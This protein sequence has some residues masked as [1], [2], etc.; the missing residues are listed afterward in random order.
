MTIRVPPGRAGRLWLQRRLAT[1]T[2]ATTLLE[3]KLRTLQKEERRLRLR[4]QRTAEWWS[5]SASEADCWLVR[6]RLACGDRAIRLATTAEPADVTIRWTT[7]M[8]A[9]YPVE[10]AVTPPRDPAGVVVVAGGAV[11]RA[12]AALREALLAGVSHAI[13]T[14]ALRVVQREIATTRQCVR[15][16]DR[17]WIPELSRALATLDLALEEQDRAEGLACRRAVHN[18]EEAR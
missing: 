16:L 9:S 10:G 3:Q 2:G 12:E 8:G 15:S 1:A 6:A 13:A 7:S 18:T 5:T 4:A 11:V 17:C 14:E